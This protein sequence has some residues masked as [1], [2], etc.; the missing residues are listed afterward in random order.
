[1]KDEYS[2]G[3]CSFCNRWSPLKNGKCPQCVDKDQI[4]DFFA[5]LFNDKKEE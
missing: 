1:M 4:P 2:F 3:N 5:D